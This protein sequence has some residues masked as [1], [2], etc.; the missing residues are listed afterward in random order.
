MADFEAILKNKKDFPDEMK[1]AIGNG[2]DMSLGELRAFQEASGQNLARS[3][4][5]ERQK[6]ADEK[7]QLAAAQEE[8][9][10]G[11]AQQAEA[12]DQ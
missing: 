6:M 3:L 7:K 2:I 11:D 9:V 1:F 8:V 4:E 12:H 5:A 10:A